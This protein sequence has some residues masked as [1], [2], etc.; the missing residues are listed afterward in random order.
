VA[1]IPFDELKKQFTIEQVAQLLGLTLKKSGEAYRG[2]CP[3]C[4]SGG[5][6]AIV[7]TPTKGV[8]YCWAAHEGGD[9][10]ALAAHMR[11]TDM[12]GAAAWLARDS[13]NSSRDK[14]PK[15]TVRSTDPEH[16][17]KPLDL[18]HEHPAVEAL[19][20]TPGDAQAL[21]IGYAGRGIMKGLVAV[22]IRLED[23]T[24]AGYI[25]VQEI[26]KLPPRWHGIATNVLPLPKR[27]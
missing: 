10:I 7:I 15:G 13:D 16:G 2:P 9:L 8:W 19:G 1:Y 4:G 25:G 6:R 11:K 5:D 22:P 18:E 26:A 24:L 12:K 17:L 23:G 14:S 27:A 20:F 3:S 21:G